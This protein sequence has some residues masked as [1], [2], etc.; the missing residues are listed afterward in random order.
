MAREGKLFSNTLLLGASAAT[1][2]ALS[3]LL[4]PFYTAALSPAEFGV[5]EILISTA[6][7]F[8]SLFS[9]YAPQATFRFLAQRARGALGV[10]TLLLGGGVLLFTLSIP[11][12][13]AIPVLRPY[14]ALLYFYVLASLSHS[15]VTHILRADG[16][17]ALFATQQLFCALASALLQ[18]LF[19][20]VLA[21]GSR[22]YLLGIALGD[23]VTVL[24]LLPALLPI[25]LQNRG[26]SKKM[27]AQMLRFALPLMPAAL[28]WWGMSAADRYILLY[29]HGA[30]AT[31]L[32]AAAGRFPALITF[33][34]GVFLEAWHYAALQ[35][36]GES[37]AARF[38]RVYALIVPAFLAIG[39][40]VMLFSPLLVRV[41]LSSS[42]GGAARI[43]GF[44]LFGAVCAGMANFLDSIYT[45]QMHTVASLVGTALAVLVHVGLGFLLIPS[46][47]AIG[48]AL[49]GALGYLAL[50]SVRVWHTAR[51]LKFPR[52]A[53]RV[54]ASLFL[55][56]GS[57]ALLSINRRFLATVLALI[58]VFPIGRQLLFSASFLYGRSRA[59]VAHILK[60]K[61]VL[62][63]EKKY[64]K[65]K[66][67]SAPLRD[68]E[69]DI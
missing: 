32:Y 47:G 33:A 58:A 42:Y 68:R 43:V 20:R 5:C 38:G 15:F 30:R 13:G 19:L 24:S 36:D 64:D 56:L 41:F 69:E 62:K 23:A 11:I 48:A 37:P 44:L 60:R 52:L 57:A 59:L 10:G 54:F 63:K 29:F 6:V 3:F 17:F 4:L 7:L 1:A 31:G 16:K 49:A 50:F 40:A 8:I 2:K 14:R 28:L 9:L 51:F 45:L 55:L 65:I 12:W 46:L 25:L 27:G 35:H 67:S 21:W 22:G 18:I 61:N 66:V 26:I 34:A 39:A 53:K